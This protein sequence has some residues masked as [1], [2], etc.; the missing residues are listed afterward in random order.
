MYPEWISN[1]LH[2][3]TSDQLKTGFTYE[4]REWSQFL[5]SGVIPKDSCPGGGGVQGTKQHR[6]PNVFWLSES[7]MHPL[8]L[9][10][11]TYNPFICPPKQ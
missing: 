1:K 4:G 8:L 9:L 5:F 6:Q 10:H 7:G 2:P 3:N 11:L